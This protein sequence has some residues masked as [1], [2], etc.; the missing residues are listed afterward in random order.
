ME[1]ENEDIDS[2]NDENED[3]T[4]QG[5]DEV[6]A[7]K[8]KNRQLFARAKKAEGFELKDGKWVKGEKTV[9]KPESQPNSNEL[10][11][12]QIAILRTEGIK[13]K[14]EMELVQEYLK[15][16]G[17][18]LLDI[19]ESKHFKSDLK[20]IQDT[21]AAQDATP[22]VTRRS[23]QS[24]NTSLDVAYARYQKDGKLPENRD[25]REKVVD[26]RRSKEK[27]NSMFFDD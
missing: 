2:S 23:G 8:Q 14:D 4:T 10:T 22:S 15:Y 9:A 3:E 12:G 13:S 5:G 1:N 26:M 11:D 20:E 27:D 18:N 16:S 25:L 24:S 6:T 19:L 7:L 17:A 21:K